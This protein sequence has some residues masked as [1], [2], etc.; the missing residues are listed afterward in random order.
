MRGY[1]RWLGRTMMAVAVLVAVAWTLLVL[2]LASDP[3]V[4]HP[5]TTDNTLPVLLGVYA[6]TAL[7]FLI[8]TVLTRIP[9]SK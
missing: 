7:S 3:T 5:V 2:A 6:I 8:G 4:Q 9:P 1:Y